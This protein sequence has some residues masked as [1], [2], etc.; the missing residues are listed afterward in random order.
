MLRKKGKM[1]QPLPEMTKY[2]EIPEKAKNDAIPEMAKMVQ[3]EK[4]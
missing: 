1:K 4:W 3:I 2:G